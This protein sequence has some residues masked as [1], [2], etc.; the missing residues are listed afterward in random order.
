MRWG[1][2]GVGWGLVVGGGGGGEGWGGWK[3]KVE[4]ASL[5]KKREKKKK[6]RVVSIWLSQQRLRQK[7]ASKK[8]AHI[9]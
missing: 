9:F 5:K 6:K 2:G 3:G 7:E 4:G 8:I 1:L